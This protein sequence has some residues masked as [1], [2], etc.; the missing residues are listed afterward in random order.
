M[1][2]TVVTEATVFSLKPQGEINSSVCFFTRT[3]GILHAT[4]YGGRKSRLRSLVSPWN[5]G[6]AYLSKDPKTG[7]FKVMD[8]D[9]KKYHMTFREN[10]V[11]YYASSLAAEIVIKTKCAGSLEGCWILVNGFI[12]GLELCTTDEQCKTGTVR[13]LWRFLELLGIRPDAEKCFHCGADFL[14]GKNK[15]DDVSCSGL[16]AEFL[17]NENQFI[18]SECRNKNEKPIFYLDGNAMHYLASIAALSPN[19][20]RKNAIGEKSLSLIKELV[21]YLIEEAVGTKL[22]SL[23]TGAGIL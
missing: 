21:F 7:F 22:K 16:G 5:T 18:C 9:V 20:A 1:P 6:D 13:F 12:D 15:G 23:E 3:E 14:A 11:K 17:I 19:E 8:F 2:K 4:L 10:L